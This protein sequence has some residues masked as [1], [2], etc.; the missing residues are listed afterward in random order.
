MYYIIPYSLSFFLT[1]Y[2]SG[3]T[4]Q[5]H[6]EIS[7][8]NAAFT[9]R[10]YSNEWRL[11]EMAPRTGE[12]IMLPQYINELRIA[13]VLPSEVG[14]SPTVLIAMGIRY[15]RPQP[16]KAKPKVTSPIEPLFCS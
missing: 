15:D 5:P 7:N 9:I 8:I 16:I 6:G 2:F 14:S 11:S 13:I 3:G 1:A 4:P 12:L 10:A